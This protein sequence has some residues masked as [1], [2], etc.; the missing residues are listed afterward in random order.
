MAR[1][2]IDEDLP[3]MLAA[4][5]RER[6]HAAHH[7]Q[8]LRLRGCSDERVYSEAQERQATLVTGDGDFGNLLKF[9]L[10]SHYG[11]VVVEYPSALRTRELAVQ[12][13]ETLCSLDEATLKGSL[14]IMQPGRVRV[15]RPHES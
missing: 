14:V 3:L 6:G 7:I 10:G 5:L 15:S 8:E 2:L 9:P 4:L 1:F 12:I 13:A 11:I